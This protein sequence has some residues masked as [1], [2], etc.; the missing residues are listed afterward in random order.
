MGCWDVFCITCGNPCHGMFGNFAKTIKEEYIDPEIKSSLPQSSKDKIKRLKASKNIIQE[1]EKLDKNTQ[2]MSNCSILL[3]DDNVIHDVSESAC[4]IQFCKGKFCATHMGKHID[5]SEYSFKE[6]GLYGIFIHTDCWKFIKKNYN[7]EL[8]FSDLPKEN[9]YSYGKNFNI[10]Y[11]AIEKYWAQNFEFDEVVLDK[12]QYLCSNP[13]KN[14]KNVSQIKKNIAKLKLKNDP[15]RV[16]PSVSATF[17]SDGDI[18][19]GKN[20]KFWIKKNNKWS[21][22]NENIV[23]ISFTIKKE[24]KFLMKIPFIGMSNTKPIFIISSKYV[25]NSY[26]LE[27]I[28]TESYEKVLREVLKKMI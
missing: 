8:K 24:D 14:D 18:R 12:K 3:I 20:K 21:E 26:K 4:N 11:G 19:I 27:L 25:K 7:I 22:I 16:G 17:Y 2:W 9:N 13:L 23:N 28:M 1:L 6:F 10:N 15:K 5:K